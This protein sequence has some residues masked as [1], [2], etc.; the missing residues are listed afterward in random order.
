MKNTLLVI[1]LQF[2]NESRHFKKENI[3]L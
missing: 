3:Y 2:E 1:H